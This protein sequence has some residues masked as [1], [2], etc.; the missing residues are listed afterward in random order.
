MFASAPR[1]RMGRALLLAASRFPSRH[2]EIPGEAGFVRRW[3]TSNDVPS[4]TYAG[5]Q[6]L[7]GSENR[8]IMAIRFIQFLMA[9]L[10]FTDPA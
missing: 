1:Q 5:S 6:F 2:M 9:R 3:M 8:S 7:D 10:G 4:V